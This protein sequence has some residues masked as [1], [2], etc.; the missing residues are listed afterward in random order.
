MRSELHNTILSGDEYPT[1][2]KTEEFTLVMTDT[3]GISLDTSS[4]RAWKAASSMCRPDGALTVL[5]EERCMAI[6]LLVDDHHWLWIV[7]VYIPTGGYSTYRSQVYS[8]LNDLRHL[9][10]S[11]HQG[12]EMI[13]GDWNG[14]VGRDTIGNDLQV[15]SEAMKQRTTEG[16][17]AFVRWIS[18]TSNLINTDT[19]YNIKE[20]GTWR[21]KSTGNWYEIDKFVQTPDLHRATQGLVT[22]HWGISD[23]MNKHVYLVLSTPNSHQRRASRKADIANDE[24]QRC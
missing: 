14:H 10:Q 20:R 24:K 19:F 17:K 22:R 3:V 23:H 9:C 8:G 15:G 5:W 7:A 13:G 16:G 18:S 2:L 21:H 4:L 6:P 1:V 12:S 11:L